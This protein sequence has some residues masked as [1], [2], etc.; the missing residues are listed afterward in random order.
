MKSLPVIIKLVEVYWSKP[1]AEFCVYFL[2]IFVLLKV[3]LVKYAFHVK[4]NNIIALWLLLVVG[5][6]FIIT[7]LLVDAWS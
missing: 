1:V 2:Y 4:S 6:L 7:S 5:F 3:I